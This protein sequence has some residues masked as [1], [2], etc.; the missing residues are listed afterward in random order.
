MAGTGQQ[1]G[2]V[3]VGFSQALQVGAQVTYLAAQLGL[4]FVIR[5]LTGSGLISL[6]F[7]LVVR[8]ATFLVICQSA[9]SWQQS[10]WHAVSLRLM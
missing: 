4:G 8:G 6:R 3:F 9:K 10:P 2:P 5:A 1:M 7:S